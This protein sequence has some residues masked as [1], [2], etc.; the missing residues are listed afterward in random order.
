MS[1]KTI[2]VVIPC[3]NSAGT[4]SRALASVMCQTRKPDEVIV[5]DDCSD[6]SGDLQSVLKL[7]PDVRL[8]RNSK[9]IGLAGSRN[10]GIWATECD[11]VAFLDADDECHPD[12]LN[13]Q[14]K[15]VASDAVVTCDAEHPENLSSRTGGNM[16]QIKIYSSPFLNML[17]PSLTGAAMMAEVSLLKSMGGYDSNLRA[18][19]DYELWIRLLR[20]GIKVIRIKKPLYYYYDSPGS[21]SKNTNLITQSMLFSV[22]KFIRKNYIDRPF[23]AWLIWFF[24]LSKVYTIFELN[25]IKST[26][27]I[28]LW[29]KCPAP[30]PGFLLNINSGFSK[31][32]IHKFAAFVVSILK[33]NKR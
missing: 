31:M 28:D 27:T 2:S 1:L 7:Y 8:I 11:I 4:L 3:Y 16:G 30:P 26:E 19:E 10:V 9:N 12:R 6:N 5:V 32:R 15:F 17:F 13:E 23:L 24:A 22:D 14:L 29:E 20:K 21:L 25:K 18:C 33:Q